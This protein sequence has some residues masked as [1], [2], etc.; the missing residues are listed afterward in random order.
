LIRNI[1]KPRRIKGIV[2]YDYKKK[3]VIETEARPLIADLDSLPFPNF[4]V[5]DSVDPE[6]G[7]NNYQM[8]SSRGCPYQCVFCNNLWSTK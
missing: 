1:S 2:F 6:K 3:M 4:A 7:L 8:I 5:F